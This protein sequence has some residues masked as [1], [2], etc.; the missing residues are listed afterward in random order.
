VP[1]LDKGAAPAAALG[2]MLAERLELAGGEAA[3]G[4][5]L[6]VRGEVGLDPAQAVHRQCM[7]QN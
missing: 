5:C 6:Q 4:A 3:V 7:T 1:A 2:G